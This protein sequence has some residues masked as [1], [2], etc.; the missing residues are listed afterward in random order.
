MLRT[1]QLDTAEIAEKSQEEMR[2]TQ[3]FLQLARSF[4]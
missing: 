4:W 1:V 2:Q 3:E